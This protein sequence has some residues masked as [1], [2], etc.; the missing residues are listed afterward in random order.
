MRERISRRREIVRGNRE[1]ARKARRWKRRWSREKL[2]YIG[3]R[4]I[5]I[6]YLNSSLQDAFV[7]SSRQFAHIYTRDA[8]IAPIYD[9][10]D[11]KQRDRKKE[12]E[13]ERE[14]ESVRRKECESARENAR[15][16]ECVQECA[17][18]EAG[19]I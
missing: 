10:G 19:R 16:I 15:E 13:R 11:K 3:V 6:I 4:I 17:G 9:R 8:E 12:R 5:N 1:R 18:R 14:S 7:Q 2:R